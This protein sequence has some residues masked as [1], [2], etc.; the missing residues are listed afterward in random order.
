MVALLSLLFPIFLSPL[1]ISYPFSLFFALWVVKSVAVITPPHDQE[2]MS[3]A[4]GMVRV[5]ASSPPRFIH[6]LVISTKIRRRSVLYHHT[7]IP[8][9]CCVPPSL[10]FVCSFTTV[11]TKSYHSYI[12]LHLLFL[13]YTHPPPHCFI[14]Y[15]HIFLRLARSSSGSLLI[16]LAQLRFTNHSYLFFALYTI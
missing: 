5:L 7:H 6:L 8:S 11:G 16:L 2:D 10:L 14:L 9:S 13:Q 4:Y 15:S 1:P 3:V 12:L